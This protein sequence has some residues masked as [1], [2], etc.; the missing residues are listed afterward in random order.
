L[1]ASREVA[2]LAG[3]QRIIL[4]KRSKGGKHIQAQSGNFDEKHRK[5]VRVSRP[6][7]KVNSC[8][9]EKACPLEPATLAGCLP[10]GGDPDEREKAF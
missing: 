3:H 2:N 8:S 1:E 6:E 9:Q 5:L 4:H 7:E 10:L